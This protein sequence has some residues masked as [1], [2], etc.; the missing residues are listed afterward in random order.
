MTLISAQRKHEKENIFKWNPI[1]HLFY[2]FSMCW[3]KTQRLKNKGSYC[4]IVPLTD[5]CPLISRGKRCQNAIRWRWVWTPICRNSLVILQSSR[6]MQINMITT[7]HKNST[8]VATC[9]VSWSCSGHIII[10][11]QWPKCIVLY[12]KWEQ[13]IKLLIFLVMV[14]WSL[15]RTSEHIRGFMK[16]LL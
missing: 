6:K 14:T 11:V 9:P 13:N 8:L 16:T 12:Y 5:I 2:F 10:V 4:V 7:A 15:G 3:K 1:N